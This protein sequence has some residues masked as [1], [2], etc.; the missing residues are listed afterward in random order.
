M[1]DR[2]DYT[3]QRSPPPQ[4]LVRATNW[5]KNAVLQIFTTE[6]FVEHPLHFKDTQPSER[7]N[8]IMFTIAVKRFFYLVFN[9]LVLFKNGVALT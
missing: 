2:L 4:Q 9:L 8:Y 7:M 5:K 3:T 1:E 6:H